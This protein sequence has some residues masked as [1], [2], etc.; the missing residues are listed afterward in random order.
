MSNSA[1]PRLP[2]PYASAA[3]Y[4]RPSRLIASAWFEHAPFAAWILEAQRPQTFVELGTHHGFSFFAFAEFADRLGLDTH[5]TAVDTWRGD[6]HAGF[7]DDSVY[8][9][10]RSVVDDVF[11]HRAELVRG[12]FS[13]ALSGF[14]DGTIDLLHIDGRHGYDDVKEDFETY[15][16][17][18]SS[19][20][21]VLFHDCFEFREGFGVHR[22]WREIAGR[23][24]SF[25][26]P[27]GHGLG[28]LAVGDQVDER[29][30]SFIE[31]ASAHEDEVADFY[32]RQGL[33]V[34]QE[35][36]VRALA[37]RVA[38]LEVEIAQLRASTSWR[39]TAPLRR[40]AAIRSRA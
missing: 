30:L 40:I 14:G 6:D 29:V 11:S 21:V 2:S 13:E 27:H 26:F 36:S 5:L 9:T 1:A 17:K 34:K 8:E 23:W 35:Y 32:A 24:P 7:Y 10:V 25:R 28:V 31:Y 20:G 12:Y 37:G 16:P 38:G 15:L 3:S 18:M 22:L 39:V 19:H 33:A 4:W